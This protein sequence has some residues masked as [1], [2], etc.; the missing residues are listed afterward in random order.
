METFGQDHSSAVTLRQPPDQD[1]RHQAACVG[2]DH[3]LF[4]PLG[5]GGSTRD[6]I[7]QVKAICESCAVSRACLDFAV[8]TGLEFG[9][10]GGRTE[11]ERRGMRDELNRRRMMATPISQAADQ[12]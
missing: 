8:R 10:F 1:W 3:E 2:V 4:F 7:Q 9:I 12:P 11:S 6:Q 5:E